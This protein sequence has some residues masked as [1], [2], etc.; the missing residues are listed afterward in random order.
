[1]VTPAPFLLWDLMED[2]VIKDIKGIY[3]AA[4]DETCFRPFFERKLARYI[5]NRAPRGSVN[6]YKLRYEFRT[7]Y[8][9]CRDEQQALKHYLG[10]MAQITIISLNGNHKQA[11]FDPVS[12]NFYT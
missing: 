6:W 9:K 1:M 3:R 5:R 2:P 12:L 11:E 4:K 8:R 7:I 10:P